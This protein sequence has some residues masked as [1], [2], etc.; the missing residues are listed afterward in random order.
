MAKSGLSPR[1]A[2]ATP[3]KT[4]RPSAYTKALAEEI[5]KL[6]ANGWSVIKISQQSNMP[7]QS[8]IYK[9]LSEKSEFSEKYA[10][11]REVQADLYADEIVDIADNV[12]DEPASVM[13]ARLQIDARKWKASKLAPKKYGDKIQQEITGDLDVSLRVKFE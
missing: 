12:M 5:C 3:K 4:G 10:R 6:V 9:W 11:A 7:T 13:K 8:T 2:V 1:K